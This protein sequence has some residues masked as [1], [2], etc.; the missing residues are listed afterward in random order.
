LNDI[1]RPFLVRMKSLKRFSIF[2]RAGNL[3]FQTTKD[4]EGWD[5]TYKGKTVDSG[6]FV[7]MIE[8]TTTDDKPAMEKG[9]ITVIR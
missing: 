3:V 7:W 4:G 2:N 9:T 8:Y 6:V 5:G 1:V